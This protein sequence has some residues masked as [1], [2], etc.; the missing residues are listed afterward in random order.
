[1]RCHDGKVLNHRVAINRGNPDA[2]IS[3]EDIRVK[4]FENCSLHLPP[5]RV[6][7]LF[8]VIMDIDQQQDCMK[9]EQL[10]TCP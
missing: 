1:M 10:M 9:L 2:P 3:N 4:F 6:Q 8:D 5:L 7:A